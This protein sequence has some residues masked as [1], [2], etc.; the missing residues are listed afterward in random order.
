MA[1]PPNFL[2]MQTGVVVTSNAKDHMANLDHRANFLQL[3]APIPDLDA[4]RAIVN[5]TQVNGA[6]VETYWHD[7]QDDKTFRYTAIVGQ[8]IPA[9]FR[10]GIEEGRYRNLS[11]TDFEVNF[12]VMHRRVSPF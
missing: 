7:T 6:G 5:G 9:A 1:A 4:N 12:T 8:G 10:Q 3:F 2:Y 11:A